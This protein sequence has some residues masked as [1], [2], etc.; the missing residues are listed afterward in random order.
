MSKSL[1]I[2]LLW[3]L[4]YHHYCTKISTERNSWQTPFTLY[5]RNLMKRSRRTWQHFFTEGWREGSSTINRGDPQQTMF[6]NVINGL[7]RGMLLSSA[8]ILSFDATQ[9]I[10]QVFFKSSP[11]DIITE[12]SAVGSFCRESCFCLDFWERV[13]G[14]RSGFKDIYF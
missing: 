2:P 8:V 10:C 1:I 5:L 6:L 7:T 14:E 4:L 9:I 13:I 3:F 12:V 11:Y